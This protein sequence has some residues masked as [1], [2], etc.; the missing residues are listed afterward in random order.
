MLC[1]WLINMQSFVG[2]SLHGVSRD[3]IRRS[4]FHEF[5]YFENWVSAHPHLLVWVIG[6]RWVLAVVAT[7]GSRR[8]NQL[9]K[10]PM[11]VGIVHWW[12]TPVSVGG[13]Y[14]SHP[15]FFVFFFV[16][17]RSPNLIETIPIL[18]LG[19]IGS[20]WWALSR[21]KFGSVQFKSSNWIKKLGWFAGWS[22]SWGSS[23]FC[24]R[25]FL[26]GRGNL[27]LKLDEC[28]HFF[29]LIELTGGNVVRAWS[30]VVW[31]IKHKHE[32][33]LNWVVIF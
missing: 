28:I 12:P 6:E 4:I 22:L 19:S 13:L 16:R 9:W 20:I 21:S 25:P 8:L 27:K 11:M 7:N 2:F 18:G 29:Q 30:R 32:G 14:V 17:A 33:V 5:W 15:C 10:R 23:Q 31:Y 26:G 24:V 3:G 1:S